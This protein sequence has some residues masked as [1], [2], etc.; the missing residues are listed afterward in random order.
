V[1]A[2]VIREH[3]GPEVIHLE[4]LPDPV[5]TEGHLIVHVRA[6]GVN[7]IDCLIRA[8]RRKFFTR[9]NFPITLGSDI[10]G[11]VIAVGNGV[12]RFKTGDQVYAL[13]N[14]FR[15]G[16]YAQLASVAESV[17]AAMPPDLSYVEAASLP[18]GSI[19]A[20]E[21]L[22]KLGGLRSG[23]QVLINGASGG[24]GVFA[25]QVA[26]AFGAEVTGT[27]SARNRDLVL[28]LG[29]DRVIDY[30][31]K[32]FASNRE[33][34]DIVFDVAGNRSFEECRHTL[35]RSGAYVTTTLSARNMILRFVTRWNVTRRSRLIL[36]KPSAA[37]LDEIRGLVQAGKLR[38]IVDQTYPLSGAGE[39][40]TY[41]ESGRSRGKL[42]ISMDQD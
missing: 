3:G 25:V 16:G 33:A 35:R 34:Y 4:N 22:H 14:R 37:T 11:D 1:R 38:T 17:A 7:S 2:A 26:K 12:R 27:C 15:G 39:A 40:H 28:S 18:R 10:A 23:H 29:A 41:Y 9:R 21:G 31:Q 36:T 6:A 30:A 42:V 32:D 8:G 19:T 20:Y 13:L 5:A 24:V